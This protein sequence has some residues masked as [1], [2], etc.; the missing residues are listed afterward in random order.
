MPSPIHWTDT[1]DTAIRRMRASHR[2]SLDAIGEQLGLHRETIRTR[3]RELGIDK[4]V[5]PEE[6]TDGRRH[7][8]PPG[9]PISWDA[10]TKGTLLDGL[11]YPEPVFR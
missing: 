11:A 9:H 6:H 1:I 2:M 5:P 10:I 8:L 4:P 3:A 7:A